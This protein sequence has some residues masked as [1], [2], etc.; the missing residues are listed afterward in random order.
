MSFTFYVPGITLSSD[1][2]ILY[3]TAD[4]YDCLWGI[5]DNRFWYERVDGN[6]C[7]AL[8]DPDAI[9][10]SETQS[11]MNINFGVPRVIQT[12]LV[13]PDEL[14]LSTRMQGVDLYVGDSPTPSLNTA[15]G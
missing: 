9:S 6:K 4:A 1:S 7:V 10:A 12:V 8:T 3:G 14:Y 13:L 11:W 2:I 15:C 5:V